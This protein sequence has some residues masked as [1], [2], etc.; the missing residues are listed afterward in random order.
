MEDAIELAWDGDYRLYVEPMVNGT[1][2]LKIVRDAD[3][4]ALEIQIDGRKTHG[5]IGALVDAMAQS[6]ADGIEIASYR[7]D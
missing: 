6:W 2:S 1:I 4:A 3:G 5:V 7:E